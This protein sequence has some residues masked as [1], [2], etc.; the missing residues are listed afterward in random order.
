MVLM[1]L[2]GFSQARA[3]FY[4]EVKTGLQFVQVT[5]K[6]SYYI[7][8]PKSYDR[9]KIWPLVVGL[10]KFG[11]GTKKYA[12]NWIKE[13]D[14]K[15]YVVLCPNWFKSRDA[16]IEGDRWLLKVVRDVQELY[17]I[18]PKKVLLTGFNDGGD[19]AYYLAL[20]NP[21]KFAGLAVIG[22]GLT[23]KYATVVF[24]G[25]IKRHPIPVYALIGENEEPLK[26]RDL[27]T[28]EIRAGIKKLQAMGVPAE[29]WQNQRANDVFDQ[30]ITS[31]IL[32]WFEKQ[33]PGEKKENQKEK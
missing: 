1:I 10:T 25:R 8:V 30:Q 13:A 7:Y 4:G 5:D 15:G 17:N 16:S 28:A 32:N 6:T 33:L 3:F 29:L 24:W 23:P 31:K 18:D 20:R 11:A 27:S 21:K 26:D 9:K 12:E 14:Q 19:Y 22:G 2:S